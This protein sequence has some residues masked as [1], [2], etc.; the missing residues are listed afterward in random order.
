MSRITIDVPVI[1]RQT[2]EEGKLVYNI[3]PL[4]F[5]HP[6]VSAR[7]YDKAEN[8][9]KSEIKYYIQNLGTNRS[10][11]SS[12]LWY[13]FFPEL[14]YNV[15]L[16]EINLGKQFIKDYFAYVV[17]EIQNH[18][19][20]YFPFI[21]NYMFISSSENSKQSDLKKE[22]AEKL[23]YLFKQEKK[24]LG[25]ATINTQ[26][27]NSL[28]NEFVGTITSSVVLENAQF[29]FE[30]DPLEALFASMGMQTDFDGGV[31]VYKVA[32]DLTEHYPNNL[33]SAWYREDIVESLQKITFSTKNTSYVIVGNKGVGKKSV[34]HESLYRYLKTVSEKDTETWQKIWH[35]DPTRIIAGMSVVGMWQ[36]RFEAIIKYIQDRRKDINQARDKAQDK[37]LFDNIVA[38]LRI[39][40]SSQNDMTLSDVLKSYIEKKSLAVILLATP[41]EWKI[42]QEK[43]RRFADLFRV[44]RLDEPPMIDA[45]K[46]VLQNRKLL[47]I[48]HACTIS[49]HAIYKLF[50]IQRNYFKRNALPGGVM[51][52][53]NQLSVKHRFNSIDVYEVEEEFQDFSGLSKQIMDESQVFQ[54]NEVKEEIESQLVGQEQAVDALSDVVHIIK[55]KLAN[56]YKPKGSFLFIGPTGVGKT[57]AAKVLSQYIS[58]NQQ[59]LMRFDMNEYIDDYAVYRLIGDN[60]NPEGQLTGKVRYNPFGIVLLDE[61]EKAHPKVHDLLLQVLDDGR[62]TDS[63][64]RTV[65]FSNTIIIMTSNIGAERTSSAIGF[66]KSQGDLDAIYKKAVENHFRPEFI[67][68]IDKIVIF[69]SLEKENILGIARL[70]INELLKRDGFVR[71]TTILNISEKAL[72]WVTNRG[73][74]QK[75]GGRALKR[76]IE[77]DLTAL[78]AQQLLNIEGEGSIIMSID[79]ENEQLIPR[80]VSLEFEK[81]KELNFL[82]DL[83]SE[84]KAKGFYGR[85]LK[86]IEKIE[87]N[88]R[89][90]ERD[91]EDVVII[92]DNEAGLD[93]QYYDFKDKL[94]NTKDNV[95]ETMLGFREA[96]FKGG[97]VIPLRL[98]GGGLGSYIQKNTSSY[99]TKGLRELM[100]D[101][102]FQEEAIKEINE[103]YRFAANQFNSMNTEMVDA[104][105]DVQFLEI[106]FNSFMD[107]S[108]NQVTLQYESSIEGKGMDEIQYLMNLHILYFEQADIQHEVDRKN[109]SIIAEAH[110]LFDII[111]G[112]QG[113]H[114]FYRNHQSPLPIKVS[115]LEDDNEYSKV[116]RLYDLKNTLTDLRTGLTND[117]HINADELK[118]L[119][120]AGVMNDKS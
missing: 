64:G 106:Q 60:T 53:L 19:Y 83:P 99:S 67:N 25:G 100:K 110:G 17:F 112:E 85:L 81:T 107:G 96:Q 72:E 24:N 10:S 32:R 56:P 118:L 71:R 36:K 93:W 15:E 62:L 87:R 68:R 22:V 59:A 76:Q 6:F 35:I 20:V 12:F 84:Q 86:Q 26:V 33:L 74:N 39:G 9:F 48:Q 111:K 44:I 109:R 103:Y 47:E 104:F 45:V 7:R 34:I 73:F 51:Q 108:S 89:R 78:S 28:K 29:P 80:I 95:K 31:E 97:P 2:K 16:F 57:Q 1:V 63:L 21:N 4:F 114:L 91:R 116:L 18:K 94:I 3:R 8:L 52:L 75:M 117:V 38:L 55:S 61:I 101:R 50:S 37:M 113:Y 105:L 115:I 27:Y 43:D 23:V 77:K 41:E 120:Y 65:D 70:Q 92:N 13:R 82:P 40:K 14:K 66:E 79:I 46:M 69:K 5:A 54:E 90:Y 58:S 30:H 88:I 11:L 49:T 98:K 119:L 102:L 42:V